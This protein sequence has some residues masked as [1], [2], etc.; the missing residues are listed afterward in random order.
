MQ[1][2]D[3]DWSYDLR[4]WFGMHVLKPILQSSA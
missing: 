4:L 1:L 2:A 3:L